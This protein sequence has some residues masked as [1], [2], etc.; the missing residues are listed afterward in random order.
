MKSGQIR[1]SCMTNMTIMFLAEYWTLET[2]SRLIY[3][4]IKMTKQLDLAIFNYWHIPFLIVLNSLFQKKKEH[5]NL[6][7]FGYWV[8]GKVK[9]KLKS[10]WNLAPV[11]Q[12]VQRITKNY[13]PCLYLSTGQVWWLH[14]LWFKRY[15]Q[16][17]T[18][19]H[20][21]ILIVTSLIW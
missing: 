17:C 18:L 16:K 6:D 3:D 19:S 14:E 21:L 5:W 2:S 10:T 13:C 8:I 7:I 1:V 9:L 15:I 20:I 11:L 4:F 12:N